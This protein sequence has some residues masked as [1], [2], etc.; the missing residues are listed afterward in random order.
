[1]INSEYPEGNQF[2]N[3]LNAD[4]N[5]TTSPEGIQNAT[6]ITATGTGTHQYGNYPVVSSGVG[7]VGSVFVKADATEYVQLFF[8]G[9][10]SSGSPYA[11]FFIGDNPSIEQ[12]RDLT[13]SIEDYGN[14]WLRL[15]IKQTTDA[16]GGITFAVVPIPNGTTTRSASYTANGESIFTYGLQLEQDA[17]Y[18]TSYIPTYGVSQTRLND[19]FKVVNQESLFGA[20]EGTFFMEF[21]F[22]INNKYIGIG[23]TYISDKITIGLNASG[24]SQIRSLIRNN[25]S[26]INL[27]GSGTTLGETIKACVSYGTNGFK[28]FMNG[29][30]EDSDATAANLSQFS[31]LI[32]NVDV[33][34]LNSSNSG[35]IKQILLFPT[36]LS[37]EECITLTTI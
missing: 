31:D 3:N 19:Y 22:D 1:M 9:G 5:A 18:P 24:S 37:D 28:L 17:T 8:G 36:A 10:P 2:F 16:S 27:Q 20:N 25:G 6:R 33:R 4:Y 11:N 12:E 13:A 30:L 26:S 29:S 21:T 15:I 14:G 7:V 32:P 23:D 35:I 34:D